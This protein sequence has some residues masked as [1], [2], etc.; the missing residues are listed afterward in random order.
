MQNQQFRSIRP[1]CIAI[2]LCCLTELIYARVVWVDLWMVR[3]YAPPDRQKLKLPFVR[4]VVLQIHNFSTNPQ[5]LDMSRCC[6]L[7][8]KSKQWSMA[9]DLSTTSRKAVQQIEQV[10]FELNPWFLYRRTHHR[11]MKSKSCHRLADTIAETGQGEL[12]QAR[13][14]VPIGFEYALI[15]TRPRTTVVHTAPKDF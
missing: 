7:N 2:A 1:R 10:E 4:F 5:H 11:N 13:I 8:N 9:F 14:F 6:G 15:D 3:V 12:V